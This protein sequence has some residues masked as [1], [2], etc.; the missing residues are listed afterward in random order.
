MINKNYLGH[1]LRASVVVFLVALPL[2]LGISLASGAP[3]FSGIL[4]GIIGGIIIGALSQS[5]TSVSGPAAGLT[6][7]VLGGIQSLGD[8]YTFTL[9]VMI[10]GL[11]QM[12]MGLIKAGNVGAFFPNSVIK[13][14]LAAIGL[15]LILKQIPHLIGFDQD[16]MGDESFL[17][18]DGRNTFT[19]L[20]A[21]FKAITPGA[22]LTGL[23][24]LGSMLLWDA[25]AKKGKK[26]FQLF[27]SALL[28][29]VMGVI[30]SNF[31][32]SNIGMLAL[33]QDHFVNLPL[34]GGFSSFF[35]NLKFPNW[36]MISNPNVYKV[37][38]TL[39]IVASLETLLSIE[40]ID[41]IDTHKRIT[42]KNRELFAQGFGNMVGGMFG[43]LP[44]TSVIVRSSA[45]VNAGGQT[46]FSAILHGVWMFL[47]VSLIPG[48]LKMIPL[49]SLAA[50]LILVGYKL[51][52]PALFKK[53]AESGRE[54]LFIFVST[55]T[56]I[57]FTDLLV[58]ITIGICIGF[59][60]IV[61]ASM[62]K[63]IVVVNDGK[64]YL[65][66]FLKD[67][68]F[69]QK[70]RMTKILSTIPDNAYVIF[71]GSN[72]FKVDH[73]IITIIEDFTE[74]CHERGI[75]YEIVKSNIAMNDF[76]RTEDGKDKKISA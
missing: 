69:L 74:A 50:I 58:G 49:S 27:P 51:C 46:K 17:Q 21:A 9:A 8:F 39:A 5:G 71:D 64:N 34:N 55:I 32:F 13:G 70:L 42:D 20:V 73:D 1:D 38:L 75:K 24:C 35:T 53:M 3:L 10:A 22:L 26:F 29:V 52:S 68:T 25:Q 6:V 36:D 4:A 31:V 2:C 37:A 14:M 7:I 23:L 12:L 61:K 30:L 16:Y 63:S 67:V 19:E 40:A 72:H 47:A 33:S 15:I 28:A 45:N 43:A 65:I 60:F 54:Q 48:L 62:S 41:K 66:R 76:F 44:V 18:M 11:I 59:L 56:A 57:L